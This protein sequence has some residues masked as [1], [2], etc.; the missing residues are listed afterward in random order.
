[1]PPVI[2]KTTG[3]STYGIP[4]IGR[5]DHTVHVQVDVSQLSQ[6]QV[7]V[8]GILKPG[9]V[10]PMHGGALGSTNGVAQ[11]ETHTV[12]GTVGAS[13][14]GNAKVIV[15]SM[16]LPNGSIDGHVCRCQQRHCRAGGGKS[17]HGFSGGC[18]H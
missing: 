7:D 13:G 1:M 9:V 15:I 3:N 14:A 17:A 6:S 8:N 18:R 12:A 5:V 4:F 10:L 16:L 11:I 2:K